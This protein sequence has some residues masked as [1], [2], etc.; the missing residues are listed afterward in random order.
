MS[1]HK[2]VGVL[3]YTEKPG[4]LRV[5]VDPGLADYYRSLIPK[6][7]VANK[8]MYPPHISVIR[9][10]PTPILTDCW[11]KYDGQEVEFEYSTEIHSGKVYYWLNA[12]CLKLEEIRTELGLPVSTEFTRPPDGYVKC[13][14]ITLANSKKL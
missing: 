7:S 10:E 9:K 6:S 4:N 8:P 2:S 12:F 13:F 14:H 1:L 11:G 5:I 3:K